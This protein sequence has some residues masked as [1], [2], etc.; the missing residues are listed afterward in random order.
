MKKF[1]P[2][3]FL[4]LVPLIGCGIAEEEHNAA[5]QKIEKLTSDLNASNSANTK[6][7]T[8]IETL[9]AENA[10]LKN[11]LEELGENVQKLLGEKGLLADDLAATKEREARLRNEQKAQKERLDKYRKVIEKFQ[12]LVSSGKLKIRIVRGRMVVEMDSNILFPTGKATLSDVGK[13]ALGELSSI[14]KTIDARDFQVAGHTDNVPI[15]SK[16]FASNWEL[17]TQRAVTVVKFFQEQGVNPKNLSAAGYAE[18]MP[19]APNTN[20]DG[21]SQNRRIE[22]VLM[23]NLDELPDLSG[24]GMN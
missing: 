7:S 17:S 9:R 4:C 2:F 21:K 13:V 23:P 24:L 6:L 3:T 8:D 14:L 12:K 18:Y 5:L 20:E 15:K 16:G 11:R 1:L 22:I 19:A 10:T